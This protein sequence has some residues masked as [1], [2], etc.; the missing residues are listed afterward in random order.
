MSDAIVESAFHRI[1]PRDASDIKGQFMWARERERTSQAP[2]SYRYRRCRLSR[3]LRMK[4][5]MRRRIALQLRR[6]SRGRTSCEILSSA[7]SV[8]RS[9]RSVHA[10]SRRFF[11]LPTVAGLRIA[12]RAYQFLIQKFCCVAGGAGVGDGATPAVLQRSNVGL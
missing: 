4:K 11:A 9:F 6:S 2:Y 8:S 5:A 1:E 12:R 7:F 10:S 3:L